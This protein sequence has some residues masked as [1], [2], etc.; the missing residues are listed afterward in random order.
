MNLME[1]IFHVAV[2]KKRYSIV[3]Y[4][5]TGKPMKPPLSSPKKKS[6]MAA[7]DRGSC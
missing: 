7:K 3:A 4:S 2:K 6:A 5:T 1:E